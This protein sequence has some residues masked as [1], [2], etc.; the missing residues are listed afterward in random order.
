MLRM[1]QNGNLVIYEVSATRR[2]LLATVLTS[3][4]SSGS[5]VTAGVP[6]LTFFENPFQSGIVIYEMTAVGASEPEY[7]DAVWS[8]ETE[9]VGDTLTLSLSDSAKLELSSDDDGSLWTVDAFDIA[10]DTDSDTAS[11]T[12]S[13]TDSDSVPNGGDA[14]NSAGTGIVDAHF[15][16]QWWFWF[17]LF[18]AGTA[19]AVVIIFKFGRS[20]ALILK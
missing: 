11:D 2:R 18:A 19:I 9:S 7:Q 15:T 10:G 14:A 13:D 3:G 5:A 20:S 12:D 16:K 8:V 4:W 6:K 1:E 17:M